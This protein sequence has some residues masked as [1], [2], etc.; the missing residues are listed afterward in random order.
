[1]GEATAV[2]M[3]TNGSSMKIKQGREMDREKQPVECEFTQCAA[4]NLVRRKRI[5]FCDFCMLFCDF[6][7]QLQFCMHG[8]ETW[9]KASRERQYQFKMM[10]PWITPGVAWAPRLLLHHG[11]SARMDSRHVDVGLRN[12]V[13][14]L[15]CSE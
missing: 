2:Q 7:L 9:Q 10:D 15:L 14:N 6:S 12:L 4:T 5:D 1:M 3:T 13:P 11:Q 8:L